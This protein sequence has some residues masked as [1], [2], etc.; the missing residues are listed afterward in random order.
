[1]GEAGNF[2]DFFP[3]NGEIFVVAGNFISCNSSIS[4]P[5]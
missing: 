4:G 2:I 1:M 5:L 3:S